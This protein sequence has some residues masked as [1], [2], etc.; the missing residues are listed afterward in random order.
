MSL[1]GSDFTISMTLRAI[2]QI[3]PVLNQA[4]QQLKSLQSQI[5]SLNTTASKASWFD[6]AISNVDKLQSKMKSMKDSMDKLVK[7]GE[8]DIVSGSIMA[9][10]LVGM[11]KSAAKVQSQ[12]A[13]LQLAGMTKQQV[14][15]LTTQAQQT[16]RKTMFNTSQVLGIDQSLAQ[17]GMNY[18]K[19]RNVGQSATYLAE[20][21]ANRNGADPNETAKQFA[22]M[23][24]QLGISM[25][26]KKVNQLADMVNRISTVTSASVATLSES[27]KYFNMTGRLQGLK[28][29]DIMFTQGLA[30]RFGLE[31]SLG[32]TSLKDFFE[33]LNPYNHMGTTMGQPIV[34]AFEQMGWLKGAKRNSKG[35]IV[36]MSGDVFHDSK[37]NLISADKIFSIMGQTYQRMGNKEQ[38][39]AL[40]TRILAQQGSPIAAAVAQNPQAFANLQN[41]M[42]RVPGVNKGIST[43]QQTFNQQFHSFTSTLAD[44]GRQVG[45]MLLPSI[46]KFLQQLNGDLPK[47]QS[48]IDKHKELLKSLAEVWA[49]LA[50]F[51]IASG[52]AKIA[53]GAPL[54]QAFGAAQFGAGGVGGAFRGARGVYRGASIYRE[55]RGVGAGRMESLWAAMEHGHPRMKKI[56]Q[57]ASRAT[58]FLGNAKNK[59]MATMK[60]AGNAISEKTVSTIKKVGSALSIASKAGLNFGKSMA[61]LGIKTVVATA[62][63]V[64]NAAATVTVKTVQ[65]AVAAA[66]RVWATVQAVLDVLLDANPIGAIIMA[67]V[68]LIGVVILVVTHWKQVKKALSD[69]W[70]AFKRFAAWIGSVFV[71][72]WKPIEAFFNSIWNVIKKV[73]GGIG[74]FFGGIGKW[75]GGLFGGGGSS[76]SSTPSV[77]G[78]GNKTTVNVQHN[79]NITSP[80]PTSAARQVQRTQNKY[81]ASRNPNTNFAY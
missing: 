5:T 3:A 49:A 78:G 33:R 50:G 62:K 60:F 9:L 37:G 76:S 45:T 32:G 14:N 48:F 38:F 15:A 66:T 42:S 43:Y 34:K 52:V 31:G 75:I 35:Q 77:A 71:A 10:P 7:S 28:P 41:Q 65:L 79:W 27:S 72:L 22:Q 69:A 6:K 57:V 2:N 80:S 25:N 55:L 39:N 29:Q 68:A 53:I 40:M 67:I 56:R 61:M 30:A 44:F 58:S 12:Q 51:K 54:K 63:L 18:S 21:E 19:I 24:E 26:P 47:L 59:G 13:S 64:A 70:D 74:S 73:I 46:T 16:M 4:S 11:V 1:A 17:V 20:L 8:S 81:I 36:G 23:S